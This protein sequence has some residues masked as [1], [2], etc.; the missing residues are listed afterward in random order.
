M[1]YLASQFAWF[2]LAAFALGFVMGWISHDGGKLRLLGQVVLYGAGIWML[3]GCLSWF[4]FLNGAPALWLE[5]G[6]LFVAAYFGG[7]ALAAAIRATQ[8]P[9]QA[10]PGLV[11]VALSSAA[12][13]AAPANVA[14]ALVDDGKTV[15][16]ALRPGRES[17]SGLAKVEGEDAIPGQRPSGTIAARADKPDDLKLIKGIGRQNEGRLHGLGIWHFDQVSAWNARNIEWIG[18]YLAF[19]GRIEREDWVGQAKALAAGVET[20]FARRAKA[21]EVASSR[22]DGSEGQANVASVTDDEFDGEKPK[23]LLTA[24]RDGKPDDLTLI[25]GIGPAI[26]A[27]LNRLGLWHFDQIAALHEAELR[28]LCA[29]AD[30]PAKGSASWA[31]DADIL[32]NGGDTAHSRA[33]KAQRQG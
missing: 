19:P 27:D 12:S 30:V 14:E 17:A 16:Q 15:I 9:A 3:A 7:C 21:G 29:F 8:E 22:D 5:S 31:E 26:A 23:N 13:V 25:K 2:L 20:D 32:A 6:L 28:Y 18:S 4:Q 33:I 1:L 24:A 10:M 11:S